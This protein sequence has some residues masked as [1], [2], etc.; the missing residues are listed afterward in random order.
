MNEMW[1]NLYNQLG[2]KNIF[3]TYWYAMH[4]SKEIVKIMNNIIMENEK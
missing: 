4:Y 1:L 2:Y 3:I